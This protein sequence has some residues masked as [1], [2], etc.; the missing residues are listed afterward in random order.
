MAKKNSAPK[1]STGR[2][3]ET[4][5]VKKEAPS[6]TRGRGKISDYDYTKYINWTPKRIIIAT[7]MVS[8]PY[9]IAVIGTYMAGV[10][11]VTALLISMLLFALG[12]YYLLRWIDKNL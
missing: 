5:S 4:P 12:T 6:V 9:V 8:I 1:P 11:I 10:K 3:I 2:R 7:A